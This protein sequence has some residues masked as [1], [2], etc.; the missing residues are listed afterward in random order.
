MA[1]LTEGS[2]APQFTLPGINLDKIGVKGDKLALKDLIGERIIVLYFYP[3]DNTKGCTMEAVEFRDLKGQ[4]TR[5]GAVVIGV[6]ADDID[7]HRKFAE[8]QGVNFPLLSDQG[9]KVAAKYGVWQEKKMYGRTLMGMVRS[10]FVIDR[11][12]KVA[13]VW[14]KV[15]PEGHA[16]EVL[17]FVRGME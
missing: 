3:R 14:P 11:S 9:G 2:R 8:K 6:S 12:G 17:E 16:R 4:F 5:A 15:S 13:K 1:Q 7:S 10:T